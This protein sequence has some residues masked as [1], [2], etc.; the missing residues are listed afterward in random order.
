MDGS[1]N[2][3]FAGGSRRKTL[4]LCPIGLGNFVMATPSL[5][6]LSAALGAQQV[7]LLALKPGI[8]RMAE[9]TGYFGRV[10]RFDPDRGGPA[11]LPRALA[12]LRAERFACSLSL[13]PS[14]DWKF[15]VFAFLVG[16]K[17]RV[18]FDYPH[19]KLPRR[20][21]HATAPVNWDAHDTDQNADLVETLLGERPQGP[22]TPL[23]P[24]RPDH[25]RAAELASERYF[26]CHPGS[27]AERGMSEKRLPPREFAGFIRRA[28][29]DFGLKCVLIGGPEEAGLRDEIRALGPDAVLTY[30][31][32][33]LTELAGLIVPARFYVGNDS[34][35]MHI[36][37]ALGKRCIAF[38]GPTDDR[39]TAPYNDCLRRGEPGPHL[40]IRRTDLDCTPCWTTRTVGANPPCIHG[41]T[42]CLK[43]MA[44]QAVWPRIADFIAD[45]P[46]KPVLE[47]EAVSRKRQ[48]RTSQ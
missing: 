11:Q 27:S 43:Q 35:L 45:L 25:P 18:G 13:F 10:H 46:E 21:Q 15:A 20:I 30:D 32:N 9:A 29:A 24:F 14:G 8:A 26:V 19:S 6:H 34:G 31:S 42:R 23:F 47:S 41:D 5:A 2:G 3:L 12:A 37:A 28:H 7:H 1:L 44:I 22:R 4:V 48:P 40:I 17:C 36:S 33:S 16:A 38:Y 39:R